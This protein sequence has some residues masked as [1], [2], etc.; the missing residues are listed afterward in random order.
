M[1]GQKLHIIDHPLVRARIT[2]LRDRETG[3]RHFREA[4]NEV[5]I[6]LAYEATRDLEVVPRHISTPLAPFEGVRL[7]RPTIIV[8]ILRA[9][10]GM[11]EAM[12]KV[13]P[14]AR[15]GHIGMARDERTFLPKSYYFKSP[16]GLADADVFLVDPMLATGHS[17]ADAADALKEAGAKR[18]T[19]TS[20]LA[21]RPGVDHFAG[22]HPEIGIVAGDLDEKLNEHA[23]IIPGLGDAG[24]RYFGTH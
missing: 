13:L 17:A 4:L 15:V 16:V 22:R 23:Y 5:A 19:L 8:P 9:G 6:L 21:C 2:I 12:L 1:E 10:L 18:I 24:D 7:A 11:A 14:E 20:I 3:T